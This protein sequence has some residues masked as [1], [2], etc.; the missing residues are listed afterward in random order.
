MHVRLA[1]GLLAAALLA[2]LPAPSAYAAGGH[3]KP[4]GG[5]SGSTGNDISWPQCGTTFPSGQAF[6]IVGVNDGLANTLN[7]CLGPDSG[8]TSGSELAWALGSSGSVAAQPKVQLYVNT[9]D[10]GNWYNGKPIGD[11]PTS[12]TSPYGDCTTAVVGG[13]TVG[14]NSDACAYVYG[15]QRAAQDVAWVSQAVSDLS[16]P[17]PSTYHWWLDV[18]TDNS[19]MSDTAMNVADL[20]GM[21]DQL[22]ASGV[23]YVGVYS[24]SS[25]WGQVT[26]GGATGSLAPLDDWIPGAMRQSSAQSNCSLPAFTGG[27]VVLTQWTRSGVDG[28]VACA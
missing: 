11:W 2:V 4:G 12:G 7:P 28:D 1:A 22:E 19:W 20:Q 9:A 18:E 14:D 24:T 25:Q 26:G 27:G 16:A 15:Q 5:S 8:G 3:G 23:T 17:A 10:P 6:G 13:Y 21:V